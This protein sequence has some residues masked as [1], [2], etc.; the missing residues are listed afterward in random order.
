MKSRLTKAI[1]RYE[2][3]FT[4][5]GWLKSATKNEC[6][7]KIRFDK[8]DVTIIFDEDLREWVTSLEIYFSKKILFLAGFR[9]LTPKGFD[10][11]IINTSFYVTDLLNDLRA[12]G[13][14][15]CAEEQEVLAYIRFLKTNNFI[16]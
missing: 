4:R 11:D 9:Y 7:D 2:Y 5:N 10:V 12:I 8:K 14:R 13:T 3:Y 16:I 1:S 6:V 15:N